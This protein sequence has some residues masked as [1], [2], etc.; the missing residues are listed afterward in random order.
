VLSLR[1]TT[2]STTNVTVSVRVNDP[3]RSCRITLPIDLPVG[4]NEDHRTTTHRDA[5]NQHPWSSIEPAGQACYP[6]PSLTIAAGGKLTLGAGNIFA[7][8]PNGQD[9]TQ[10]SV[11]SCPAGATVPITLVFTAAVKLQHAQVPASG[12]AALYLHRPGSPNN[13]LAFKYE[14]SVAK[15]L[16]VGGEWLLDSYHSTQ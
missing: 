13:P 14:K 15:L 6:M 2:T 9:L 1:A 12:F 16:L 11:P 8:N 4:S 3:E 5:P 10:I 7:V